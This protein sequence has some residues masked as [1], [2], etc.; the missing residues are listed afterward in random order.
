MLRGATTSALQIETA[1]GRQQ[2]GVSDGCAGPLYT[3][4]VDASFLSDVLGWLQS[5]VDAAGGALDVVQSVPS[6]VRAAVAGVAAL[7]ETNVITGL[8]V[9]GDTIVLV[10]ASAVRTIPEG[11]V[12]GASVAAGA[13]LGEIGGYWLGR[14]LGVKARGAWIRRHA[15]GGLLERAALYLI[16]RGGPAILS[17]RF[18]PVLRTVMPFA[19][20]TSEYSFKRFVAWSAPASVLWSGLYV[21]VYSLAAAP[22]RDGSASAALGVAFALVGLLLFFAALGAQKWFE[23]A[24]Q[25]ARTDPSSDLTRATGVCH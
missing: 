7:L 10:A 5:M 11:L 4:R 19:V 6:T 8:L 24:H 12:L 23:R 21:T 3:G 9:P 13:L 25:H 15:G 22:I 17:A 14:W 1:T 2:R 16:R 18:V 20:G